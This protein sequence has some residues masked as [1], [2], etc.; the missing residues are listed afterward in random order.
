M[1]TYY[2]VTTHLD[3]QDCEYILAGDH[4]LDKQDCEY[5][6]A[7]DHI[8]DEQDCEYVPCLPCALGFD[9]RSLHAWLR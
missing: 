1:N 2:L 6:L 9:R 3:K 8:L 4:T 7:G 5:I